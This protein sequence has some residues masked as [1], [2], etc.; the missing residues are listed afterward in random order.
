MPGGQI[1]Y[2]QL[3]VSGR[4]KKLH[5]HTHA[6]TRTRAHAHT[7][8]RTHTHTHTHTHARLHTQVLVFNC[9]ATAVKQERDKKIKSMEMYAD[10]LLDNGGTYTSTNQS[11][12]YL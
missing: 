5:T 10:R 9:L 4:R 6:H 1:T 12:C 8:A 11:E 7:H 3:L 2:I